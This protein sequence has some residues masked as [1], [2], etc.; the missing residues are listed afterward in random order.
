MSGY[1]ISTKEAIAI[2]IC[3]VIAYCLI[4]LP[5][6]ILT[7]QKSAVLLNIIYV[8]IIAIAFSCLIYKLF[9]SFSGK[10][11]LDISEYLGGKTFRN[12]LGIIF[13]SYLCI[14]SAF[15]L[16]CF[17]EGLRIIYY[18]NTKLIFIVIVFI[19]GIILVNRLNSNSIFKANLIVIPIAFFSILFLLFANMK[20]FHIQN[21]YPFFGEGIFNTF[22][23]GLASLVSFNGLF[24]LYFLPPLLNE[25]EKFKKI[26]ITS[27][28]LTVFYLIIV[29]II[30]LFIFSFFTN[31]DE[32][33]PLY[34]VARTVEF[35][36]FFQRLESIFLLIWIFAFGS[37]VAICMNF[38]MQIFKKIANLKETKHLAA[39]FGLLILGITLF[40]KNYSIA[41]SFETDIFPII[42]IG[43]V[44]ILCIAIL[45]LANV[46]LK[47]KGT[48]IEK[49]F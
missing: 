21:M 12:I 39:P 35:G 23:T 15:L 29:F 9:K 36:S 2:I 22:V 45:I 33:I 25:P 1:K 19:I 3:P 47:K 43:T 8:S 31:I 6:D 5:R 41:K 49:D 7:Y 14:S 27:C 44:F 28:L 42:S 38:S 17:S 4:S 20:I 13:A 40:P 46:K 24:L 48:K 26:A 11:I 18:S 10:D 32:I 37:Y 30:F 16:R 34:T